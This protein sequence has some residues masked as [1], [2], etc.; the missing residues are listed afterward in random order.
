M[1]VHHYVMQCVTANIHILHRDGRL[2]RND[3]ISHING[4]SLSTLP[5]SDAVSL[6]QSSRGPVELVVIREHPS[7]ATPP[8]PPSLRHPPPMSP[9]RR[10]TSQSPAAHRHMITKPSSGQPDTQSPPSP[11]PT[12]TPHPRT[13]QDIV[14][15]DLNEVHMYNICISPYTPYTPSNNVFSL[16]NCI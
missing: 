7:Q 16:S 6:L 5:H 4:H 9:S 15:G 1:L 12:P 10:H 2:R 3:Q 11:P 13:Q 14:N 8:S